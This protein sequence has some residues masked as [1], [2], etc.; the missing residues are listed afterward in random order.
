MDFYLFTFRFQTGSFAGNKL[1][2]T[3][4][5]TLC[6]EYMIALILKKKKKKKILCYL[7]ILGSHYKLMFIADYRFT[8]IIM[9]VT[10]IIK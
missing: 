5:S 10:S 6:F 8:N 4:V 3:Q 1:K 9:Q 7:P 2:Q